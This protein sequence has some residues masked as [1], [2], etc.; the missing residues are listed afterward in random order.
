VPAIEIS[1]L[2]ALEGLSLDSKKVDVHWN[3]IAEHT[4]GTIIDDIRGVYPAWYILPRFLS[5]S[6]PADSFQTIFVV[7]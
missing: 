1:N 3:I 7:P 4:G 2:E 5:F 6:S